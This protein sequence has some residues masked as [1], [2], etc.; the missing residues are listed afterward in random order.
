MRA[1]VAYRGGRRGPDVT[2]EKPAR[3][4]LPPRIHGELIPGGF[5]FL[6]ATGDRRPFLPLP[7]HG[8]HRTNR[9]QP[10]SSNP[11]RCTVRYFQIPIQLQCQIQVRT[12]ELILY[13]SAKGSRSPDLLAAYEP[14]TSLYSPLRRDNGSHRVGF[15]RIESCYCYLN[16]NRYAARCRFQRIRRDATTL[17]SPLVRKI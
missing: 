14:L 1:G 2:L 7:E 3:R 4:P 16:F 13:Y 8:L 15:I 17:C 12:V 11:L 5:H 10:P 6:C 9:R